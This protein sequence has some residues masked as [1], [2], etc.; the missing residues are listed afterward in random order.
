MWSKILPKLLLKQ[1]IS[2]YAFLQ[3]ASISL[4]DSVVNKRNTNVK[5]L[6]AT[7]IPPRDYPGTIAFYLTV[8]PLGTQGYY[9]RVKSPRLNPVSQSSIK[10]YFPFRLETKGFLVE[11]YRPGQTTFQKTDELSARFTCRG[12]HFA[13]LPT[14]LQKLS[15]VVMS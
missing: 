1:M 15:T 9:L 6:S 8:V 11:Y 3:G 5:E 7:W 12:P 13:V 4:Q 2:C 14:G 10:L